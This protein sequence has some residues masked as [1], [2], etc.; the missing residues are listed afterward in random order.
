MGIWVTSVLALTNFILAPL[1][2]EIVGGRPKYLMNLTSATQVG[3]MSPLP[4]EAQ[5]PPLR[6]HAFL[7][8]H[9]RRN[10]KA[11]SSNL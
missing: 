4:P 5:T 6:K 8:H 10:S 3:S 2:A 11:Q 1:H 7:F 9:P